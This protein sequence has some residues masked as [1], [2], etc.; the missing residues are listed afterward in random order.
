MLVLSLLRST[1]SVR[2]GIQLPWKYVLMSRAIPRSL[3]ASHVSCNSRRIRAPKIVRSADERFT[4]WIRQTFNMSFDN[5]SVLDRVLCRLQSCSIANL[6]AAATRWP[7]TKDYCITF[8]GGCN[9]PI[10]LN[11]RSYG[12]ITL[13]YYTT[14]HGGF[15]LEC[16][17]IVDTRFREGSSYLKYIERAN[18]HLFL[19]SIYDSNIFLKNVVLQA[20]AMVK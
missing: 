4:L 11:A 7:H 9:F 16:V 18:A 14:R 8:Q 13:Y 15:D 19:S 12:T 10:D 3:T 20:K 5:F 1:G 17:E 2:R 6:L